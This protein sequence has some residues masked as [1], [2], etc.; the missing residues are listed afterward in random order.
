MHISPYEQGNRF[1]RD[2]LRDRRLLLHKREIMRLLDVYKRQVMH[3]LRIIIHIVKMDDPLLVRFDDL[4]RQQQAAGN[5][6][7]LSLIHI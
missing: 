4:G 2:P 1:N 7:A 6:L 3:V 5:I